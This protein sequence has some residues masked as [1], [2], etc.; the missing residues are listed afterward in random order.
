M[1]RLWFL[2]REESKRG[3]AKNE[4]EPNDT[5]DNHFP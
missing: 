2:V 5:L 1:I 4:S 3:S